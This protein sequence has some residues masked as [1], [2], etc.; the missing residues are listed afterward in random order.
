MVALFVFFWPLLDIAESAPP[1]QF[2]VSSYSLTH[3]PTHGTDFLYRLSY[4]TVSFIGRMSCCGVRESGANVDSAL[5]AQAGL[6][7]PLLSQPPDAPLR[8]GQLWIASSLA[9]VLMV[10]LHVPILIAVHAAKFVTLPPRFGVLLWIRRVRWASGRQD[11]VRSFP[12]PAGIG[13]GPVIM[14][15]CV[16]SPMGPFVRVQ[17]GDG[18]ENAVP[19]GLRMEPR[20][21]IAGRFTLLPLRNT[22]PHRKPLL[23]SFP[24]S[25]P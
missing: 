23:L 11:G 2:P 3:Q 1:H 14:V 7:V 18:E 20:A 9:V 12:K 5:L 19:M 21:P 17:Y 10:L 22:P 13:E 6:P 4:T 24:M 15:K 25:Y 16:K 8:F